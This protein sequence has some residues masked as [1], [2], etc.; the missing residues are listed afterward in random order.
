VGFISCKH[1][2]RSTHRL[3]NNPL[4]KRFADEWRKINSDMGRGHGTLAYLLADDPNYPMAEVTQRD[5]TVAATVIQWLGSPVGQGFL[6]DVQ[7][8]ACT[9]SK[10]S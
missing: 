9:S 2:G 8:R 4:E 3:K 10:K 6:E 1:E 5:A 7:E